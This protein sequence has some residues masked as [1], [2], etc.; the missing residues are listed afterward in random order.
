MA[1]RC[2]DELP[3]WGDEDVVKSAKNSKDIFSVISLP[4]VSES[5]VFGVSLPDQN[6]EVKV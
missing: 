4:A 1:C 3:Y 6:E 5:G 2:V